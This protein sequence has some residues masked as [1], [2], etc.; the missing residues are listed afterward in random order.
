MLQLGN[1]QD[2]TGAAVWSVGLV[3]LMPLQAANAPGDIISH[4]LEIP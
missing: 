2:L 1:I 3:W 4:S